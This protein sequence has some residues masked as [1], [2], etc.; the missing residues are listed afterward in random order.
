MK[1][2]PLLN[3]MLI[4][5]IWRGKM[6]DHLSTIFLITFLV[7]SVLCFPRKA[8]CQFANGADIGWLSQMESQGY[9]FI[10]DSGLQKS[11]L[12]IL[13]EHDI[14]A[15]RFR[16][17]VNP[18]DKWCGKRDVATMSHRADSL[19]FKVMIDFHYS[20]WWAD[21]GKQTKPA[22][23]KNHTPDQLCTD[24][25]HHTFEVMDTLKTIGVI[26]EWV[27]IGNETNNGMLWPEGRAS[28][29]MSDFAAMVRSGYDAVK[30]VDSTI[31]VI[32][33]LSNGYDNNMFRWM[34]DGLKNNNV[35]W[36]MIGLSVYPAWANGMTWSTCNT[37]CK[38]NMQ[39]MI[40]RYQTKVMVVETGYDYRKT[41]EA[42]NF[43]YD[44]IEKT[45]IAGGL[46]VFYWEPEGY[47]H[48]Y[49]LTA[50]N[51]TTKKP[52]IA[53]DAFQGI[54]HTS[55]TS[56]NNFPESGIKVFPNPINSDQKLTVLLSETSVNS[57]IRI[58]NLNGQSI[59]D[60]TIGTPA[61]L[62]I[63]CNGIKPGIYFIRVTNSKQKLIKVFTVK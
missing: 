45:K 49:D 9:I 58:Y 2:Q 33:H 15:L 59:Y 35:K 38:E 53:M 21:P 31:Q 41:I 52:T 3:R 60:T 29:H 39:D 25:Y 34:F 17:W 18:K 61:Q 4:V 20:D 43:L 26:P 19:G 46:G 16:V 23:W 12:E 47:G 37:R 42:N 28:D 10:N 24:I 50:W 62:E 8:N 54:K 57:I 7:L 22:A 14:N 6:N 13:K 63:N 51:P 32:V 48:S 1:N 55:T 40:K 27:Q 30:A 44:L 56:V 11:C 5:S 36:D